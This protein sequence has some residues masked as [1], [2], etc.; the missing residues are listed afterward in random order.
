MWRHNEWGQIAFKCSN[1]Y[2][3][4][5]SPLSMLCKI[6]FKFALDTP[7]INKILTATTRTYDRNSSNASM[8]AG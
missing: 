1:S 5:M 2:K 4:G 7:L 8:L 3:H 6:H